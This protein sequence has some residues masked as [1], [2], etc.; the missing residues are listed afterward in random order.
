VGTAGGNLLPS[1]R[2]RLAR[3]SADQSV[4]I[5]CHCLPGVDDGP[6]TVEEAIDLCRG[7]VADGITTVIATPHQ[8]G[9]YEGKNSSQLIRQAVASLTDLL[10]LSEI[11]LTIVPGAD[12]R[13]DDQ[14][15]ALLTADEIMTLADGNA[16]ILLELPH[17]TMID[18]R[19]LIRQLIS[20]GIT[21]VVSHP[22]RHREIARKPGLVLPWLEIGACL[23]VTAGSLRGMFGPPAERAAW[24]LLEAGLV[25]LIASDAHGMERRAPGM[26]DAIDI[27]TKRLGHAVARRLCIEN[28]L[29]VLQGVEIIPPR[30]TARSSLC[31]GVS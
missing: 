28:P 4:D 26:S 13:V 29:R 11:P 22:E 10:A 20:R 7:L 6:Q 31:R 24:Q 30:T 23:Q 8:L 18:L 15:V 2:S 17:E 21:P 3:F 14:L 25:S 5:H 1:Q 16:S 27:L 19:P 9:A 12:V